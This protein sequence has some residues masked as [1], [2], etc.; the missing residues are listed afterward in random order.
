MIAVVLLCTIFIHKVKEAGAPLLEKKE[1]GNFARV[2]LLYPRVGVY[3]RVVE[4]CV[5][6]I[7]SGPPLRRISRSSENRACSTRQRGEK[8][9][10]SRVAQRR[11][12]RLETGDA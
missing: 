5:S 3:S 8:E 1:R 12:A 6:M 7:I 11:R 10:R 9:R 2:L 4:K